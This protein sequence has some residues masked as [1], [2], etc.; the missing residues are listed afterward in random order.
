MYLIVSWMKNLLLPTRFLNLKWYPGL[1]DMILR[2]IF[3]IIGEYDLNQLWLIFRRMFFKLI[4]HTHHSVHV[5][6]HFSLLPTIAVIEPIASISISTDI[7]VWHTVKR[8]WLLCK[9][10]IR[11][12]ILRVARRLIAMI[13]V[14]ACWLTT[15]ELGL[16]AAAVWWVWLRSAGIGWIYLF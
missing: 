9:T 15:E 6:G 10:N 2:H 12:T 3:N 1:T 7:T 5:W 11:I 14:G 16:R 13:A 8:G 4:Y